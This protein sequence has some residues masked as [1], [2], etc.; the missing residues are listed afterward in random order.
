M[1]IYNIKVKDIDT[2]EIKL[3]KYKGRVMLIVNVA[4]RCSFTPQYNALE[5]LHEKYEKEGLSI[6]GFPCNQFLS[7]ESEDEETIKQFC[8]LNYGVKF[9]MFSKVEVNGDKAHSL[10][11]HLK[12]NIGGFLTESIKWNFT[13]FLV[14]RKGNVV[15]RYSPATK[16]ESIEKDIV[17]LLHKEA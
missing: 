7:Q 13:K 15:K 12:R 2:K 10:F 17:E 11:K 6:L 16:P 5:M 1:N 4:S 3:Q 14:D 9:D 8:T